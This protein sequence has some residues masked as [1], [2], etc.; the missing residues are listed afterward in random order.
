MLRVSEFHT[1]KFQTFHSK[2]YFLMISNAMVFPL[3]YRFLR[4]VQKTNN[5]PHYVLSLISRYFYQSTYIV[6]YAFSWLIVSLTFKFTFWLWARLA[7]LQTTIFF[8]RI[9][10]FSL[11]LN[12]CYLHKLFFQFLNR[13]LFPFSSWIFIWIF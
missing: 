8:I 6:L 2:I 13:L 12:F 9:C 1:S 4:S 5:C 10:Q 11:L 3:L 7:V